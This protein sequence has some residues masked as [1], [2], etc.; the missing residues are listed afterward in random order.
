MKDFR[1]QISPLPYDYSALEPIISKE[2]LELHHDKHH[3]AYVDGANKALELL[4]KSRE[5]LEIN[6]KAV[7]RD[8]SFN[9]NGHLL[10]EL[11]WQNMQPR[12]DNNQPSEKLGNIL[13][14]NFGNYEAFKK[15]FIEAG[16]SV[17]GAGWVALMKGPS[18]KLIIT[19]IQNHN[20]LGINGFIPIL[21]N[22][23]WEHS[24]YLDYKN[25]RATYLTKWWD[26]VNWNDVEKRI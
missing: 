8:L 19:Q 1:Y 7:I 4:E 14:E 2:I 16:K 10:H 22:D 13:N 11:Y 21:V 24:Y 18:E 20:L 5:G 26:I 17:E 3:Q 25:D 9:L 23:V 12:K 15:E 6:Y